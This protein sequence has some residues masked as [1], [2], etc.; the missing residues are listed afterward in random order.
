MWAT[1]LAAY[2]YNIIH[3]PGSKITNANAFSW[4]PLPDTLSSTPT[5]E[6]IIQPIHQFIIN[7]TQIK[8]WSDKDPTL[9]CVRRL[10]QSGWTLSTPYHNRHSELSV[11]DGCVLWD[12]RVI[13]PPPGHKAILQMLHKTH[14]GVNRMKSSASSYVWWTGLYNDIQNTVQQ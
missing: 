13:V 4:L 14:H 11:I 3:K 10:V 9:S 2:S 1:T 5:P 12:S 6:N 8:S 7:A